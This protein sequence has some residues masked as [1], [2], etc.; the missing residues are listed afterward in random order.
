MSR[1]QSKTVLITGAT[2]G[3]GRAAARYLAEQ[4]HRVIATGRKPELLA[5]L[6]SEAKQQRWTLETLQLDVTV[7][8]SIAAAKAEVDRRTQG[9]GIDALVNNAG[10]GLAGPVEL[11]SDEDVRAQ[12]DTN[13][14]GLLAVTRAFLPAMRRR[15]DGRVIN[16]SSIGGKVTFPFLGA[17]NATKY[18]VESLSDAL[19]VE[20]APFNVHVSLIEPGLIRT[21]FNAR[22]QST[23]GPVADAPGEYEDVLRTA[24]ARL[25]VAEDRFSAGPETVARAIA[26][27]VSSRRPSARYVAPGMM[28]LA[29]L[30]LAVFPSRW[31]DAALS[32][33]F[34][35]GRAKLLPASSVP[36]EVKS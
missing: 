3:I 28:W 7:P 29:V 10:Y 13:V 6:E 26:K 35:F 14:H 17:Y 30:F 11:V 12:F 18:A 8:E 19:R 9:R 25:K 24:L 5:Q 20:L 2:T 27:A 4:G 23:L 36:A 32:W 21:E 34:G 31:L 16:I 33:A 1:I 15:R 22:A